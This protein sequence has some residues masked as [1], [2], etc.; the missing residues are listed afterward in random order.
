MAALIAILIVG[1]LVVFFMSRLSA[2]KKELEQEV[3]Q[4]GLR[5]YVTFKGNA[6]VSK[7]EASRKGGDFGLKFVLALYKDTRFVRLSLYYKKEWRTHDIDFDGIKSVEQVVLREGE[8]GTYTVQLIE[9]TFY[10]EAF[11][12]PEI[13]LY[14]GKYEILDA[15]NEVMKPKKVAVT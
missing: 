3:Q 14:P 7:A 4:D 5:P 8:Y 11:P 12:L 9:M 13:Y 15:L 1:A 6:F 10:D 2:K